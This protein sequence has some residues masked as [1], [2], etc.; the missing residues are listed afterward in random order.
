MDLKAEII[1]EHSRQQAQMIADWVGADKKRLAKLMDIFLNDDGVLAQRSSWIV[2]MVND[3]HPELI[4]PYLEAVIKRMQQPGS[5]DAVKRN[6]VRILEHTDIPEPVHGIVMTACFDFLA[7][8]KETIAVRCFSMNVLDNLSK[9]YPEIR[10][11]LIMLV[12][13]QLENGASAG[14]KVRARRILKGSR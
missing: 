13:N 14:F 7:D 11:E 12:Q 3:K 8:P 6:M 1:R 2:N 10:P 9:V 5:H 4:L